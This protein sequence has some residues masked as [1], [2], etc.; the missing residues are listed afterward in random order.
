MAS[1][2][3]TPGLEQLQHD[4]SVGRVVGTLGVFTFVLGYGIGPILWSP[5][6]ENAAVGRSSIYALTL[7]VF[8]ILQIPTAL[9]DNIAG[10]CILRFL[11]GFS[12]VLVW[13]LVV[14]A[15]EK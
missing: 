2:V 14:Q 15:L 3:Y 7:L 10:F 4:L 1:A 9:V 13:Q 12:L 5:I 6:S 8:V 11:G